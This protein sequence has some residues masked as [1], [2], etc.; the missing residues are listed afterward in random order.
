M[1]PSAL[2]GKEKPERAVVSAR[3]V[4]FNKIYCKS[5]PRENKEGKVI[6]LKSLAEIT[7]NALNTAAETAGLPQ[8]FR[9]FADAGAYVPP[10]R[11]RNEVI[12]YINCL[13]SS[14]STDVIPNPD[15]AVKIASQ[16]VQVEML[17]AIPDNAELEEI[18][19]DIQSFLAPITNTIQSVCEKPRI[20][21]I[22]DGEDENMAYTVTLLYSLLS[23]G[24]YTQRDG[25][26]RS[27][28][29]TLYLTAV[30]VTDGL[31]SKSISV[32]W[33]GKQ[34]PYTQCQIIRSLVPDLLPRSG[35]NGIALAN[36]ISTTFGLDMELPALKTK[37]NA[38]SRALISYILTGQQE[39]A[40]V[41]VNVDGIEGSYKMKFGTSTLTVEGI[42]N[43]GHHAAL[44]EVVDEDA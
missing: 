9:I 21:Q 2:E 39:V 29:F 25:I 23:T 43:A 13:M 34:M 44:V 7:E 11:E 18:N 19:S 14:V 42:M 6:A 38:L 15:N 30:Y 33:N 4:G 36:I 32:L 16:S 26:G 37:D 40:T 28:T 17:I 10:E 5:M 22:N 35:S 27:I 41:T 31:N 24:E 3:G 20:V 1:D 8:R 12:P